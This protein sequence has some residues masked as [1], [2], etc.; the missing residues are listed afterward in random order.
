MNI[1][2]IVFGRKKLVADID[3]P[4]PE[5]MRK[6]QV[7][8]TMIRDSTTKVA[9]QFREQV[10]QETMARFDI[11]IGQRDVTMPE[12]K[13]FMEREMARPGLQE[14][15]STERLKEYA[16]AKR[17]ALNMDVDPTSM[18]SAEAL[19]HQG[20]GLREL[21]AKTFKNPAVLSGDISL[22]TPEV[23]HIDEYVKV[24]QGMQDDH[25]C[26]HEDCS[27]FIHATHGTPRLEQALGKDAARKMLQD[28]YDAQRT[29]ADTI[30]ITIP[31][32]TGCPAKT[33]TIPI[34][35]K[36]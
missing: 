36:K 11:F 34:A 25:S 4:N 8:E 15:I 13:T 24:L 21:D 2:K 35:K 23:L 7:V 19:H 1:F 31:A 10:V 17:R 9:P 26:R 12:I 5:E 27:K 14:L 28:A 32:V 20:Q 16:T 29:G 22:G 18:E 33:V 6:R 3:P 30:T